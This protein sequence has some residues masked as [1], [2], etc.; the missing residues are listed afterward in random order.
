MVSNQCVRRWWL[1]CVP[2]SPHTALNLVPVSV[3]VVLMVVVKRRALEMLLLFLLLLL[4]V[5]VQVK[6]SG[7]SE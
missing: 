4:R 3:R 1:F 7:V 6:V 2:S 5:A